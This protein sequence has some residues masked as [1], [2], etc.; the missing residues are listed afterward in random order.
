MFSN[1]YQLPGTPPGAVG[2]GGAVFR[3]GGEMLPSRGVYLAPSSDLS[4]GVAFAGRVECKY[5]RGEGP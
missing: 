1:V 5:P 4:R 2:A 3:K